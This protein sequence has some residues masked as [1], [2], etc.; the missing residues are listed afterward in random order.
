MISIFYFFKL[1]SVFKFEYCLCVFELQLT[2]YKSIKSLGMPFLL[3]FLIFKRDQMCDFDCWPS[4]NFFCLV[5]NSLFE[6]LF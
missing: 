2:L 3:S 6:C 1:K 4:F 5:A